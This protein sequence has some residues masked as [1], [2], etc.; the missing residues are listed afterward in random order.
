VRT[1]FV[2][3]TFDRIHP[4]HLAFLERARA[5]GDRLVVGVAR[6]SHVRSLKAKE[7][8]FP[9]A[10]RRTNVSQQQVVDEAILCDETLGTYEIL[11][12]VQPDVIAFGYDQ[13][14]LETDVRRHVALTGRCVE[15]VRIAHKEAQVAL[16]LIERR[17]KILLQQRRDENPLW[18]K[19]WEFPGGKINVNEPPQQAIRREVLEETGLEVLSETHLGV[20]THDWMLPN[21]VLRVHLHIFLCTV[22]E[23]EVQPEERSCYTHAWVTPT[24]AL[25]YDLLEANAEILKNLYLN[26]HVPNLGGN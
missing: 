8:H 1:V 6:D 3:G 9:E 18:D 21:I 2:F 24:D 5:L 15:L 16:A 10:T 20:H 23:G 13:T 14:A 19:K 12:S 17:G 22:R 4:G 26:R 11:E 25:S 7:P